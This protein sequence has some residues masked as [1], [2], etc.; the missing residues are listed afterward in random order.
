MKYRGKH[1]HVLPQNSHLD[2][3]WVYG[4]MDI[5]YRKITLL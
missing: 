2:G 4:C 3:T 5:R 1:V